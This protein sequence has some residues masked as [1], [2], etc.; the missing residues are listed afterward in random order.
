MVVNIPTSDRIS[1]IVGGYLKFLEA[2]VSLFALLYNIGRYITILY[3][4]T[5]A[6]HRLDCGVYCLGSLIL[7][8]SLKY[9]LLYIKHDYN[10]QEN[11]R[12]D[13]TFEA[14]EIVRYN[15]LR[16]KPTG[17]KI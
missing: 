10:T 3:Y 13:C 16:I 1:L 9:K 12:S 15:K 4:R 5:R 17:R 6:I 2:T 8:R 7:C 11:K 14:F